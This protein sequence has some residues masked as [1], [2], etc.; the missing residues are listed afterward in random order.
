MEITLSNIFESKKHELVA[1]LSDL[2]LPRDAQRLQMVICNFFAV[3]IGG[4]YKDNLTRYETIIV[5]YITDLIREEMSLL[6]ASNAVLE[7]AGSNVF[8]EPIKNNS[9]L[10]K[11]K[12]PAQVGIGGLIGASCGLWGTFAATVVCLCY[13]Y[14][15]NKNENAEKTS[16]GIV[17]HVSNPSFKV[18][19]DVCV[20]VLRSVCGKIDAIVNV[21]RKGLETLKNELSS[22]NSQNVT[23]ATS[24]RPLLER[25]ADIY[26]ELECIN[27]IPSEAKDEINRLYKA[28]RMYNCEIVGFTEETKNFYKMSYGEVDKITP[29]KAAVLENG[30]VVIYGEC[31]IPER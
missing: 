19:V 21:Y 16:T 14:C 4:E 22:G 30:H 5:N 29:V 1:E 31:F 6:D 10:E 24:H 26:A 25:F 13:S 3:V 17:S 7:V 18:N 20:R 27:N 15:T 11:F 9:D 2:V 28:L 8:S 23:F 12:M